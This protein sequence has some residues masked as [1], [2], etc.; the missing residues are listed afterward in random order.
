MLLLSRYICATMLAM[1]GCHRPLQECALQSIYELHFFWL[2]VSW[3]E[4]VAECFTQVGH[5]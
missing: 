5:Q 1:S 2:C 3:L 4:I